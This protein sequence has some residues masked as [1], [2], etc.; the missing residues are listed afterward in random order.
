MFKKSSTPPSPNIAWANA[1][2]SRLSFNVNSC[3]LIVIVLPSAAKSLSAFNTTPAPS[4]ISFAS[5]VLKVTLM[6]SSS[7]TAVATVS[8]PT[9]MSS[10]M[11]LKSAMKAGF[12]STGSSTFLLI[13]I[14]VAAVISI[15]F[16]APA[17]TS[18]PFTV[19]AVTAVI[20][21]VVPAATSSK[22]SAPVIV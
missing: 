16:V 9:F 17:A 20:V 21:R 14:V 11:S 3:S 15:P 19:M 22:L 8:S 7:I 4:K 12:G 18:S 10:I 13:V 2:I 6:F 1:E 5:L